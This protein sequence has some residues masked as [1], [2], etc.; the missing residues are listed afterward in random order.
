MLL[1][2]K[3]RVGFHDP[4][5]TRLSRKEQQ[6]MMTLWS[7]FRSPLMIGGEMRDNDE[8]TLSLLI[9]ERVLRLLK[10]S[11]GARQLFRDINQAAWHSLDDDGSK[12][13]VLD[14]ETTPD[15]PL[16]QQQ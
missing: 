11:S 1:M 15:P 12:Y 7:I 2:E 14:N 10:H 9:N 4:G 3:I 8:W 13:L 16:W 6:T 5:L